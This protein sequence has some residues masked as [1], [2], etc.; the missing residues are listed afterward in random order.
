MTTY[1]YCEESDKVTADG[2]LAREWEDCG[3][4]V[5]RFKA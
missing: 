4:T 2:L 1:Y 5:I 3:Y